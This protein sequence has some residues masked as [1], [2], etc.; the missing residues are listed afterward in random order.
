MNERSQQLSDFKAK[1]HQ[2]R[3][4]A[5]NML[6]RLECTVDT[7]FSCY[8]HQSCLRFHVTIQTANIQL[9]SVHAVINLTSPLQPRSSV[10]SS[11]CLSV[12]VA[13]GY[14][15]DV[16]YFQSNPIQFI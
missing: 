2:I 5:D 15:V 3:F 9:V 10:L 7:Q 13:V 6:Y 4:R 1:M 8:V 11:V 12:S 14:C 16:E